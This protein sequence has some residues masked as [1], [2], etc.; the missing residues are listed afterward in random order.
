MFYRWTIHEH[1]YLLLVLNVGLHYEILVML[2]M[3]GVA[4]INIIA[5][6]KAA[7]GT[8][9]RLLHLHCYMIK[10]FYVFLG[11]ALRQK[12]KVSCGTLLTINRA[13]ERIMCHCCQRDCSAQLR[14]YWCNI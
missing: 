12:V 4:I 11:F 1:I 6:L 10:P 3:L 7:L 5:N 14:V 9:M 2:P 8:E 13:R